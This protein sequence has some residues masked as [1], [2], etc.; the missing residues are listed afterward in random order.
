MIQTGVI[1]QVVCAVMAGGIL[2]YLGSNGRRNRS[3]HSYML[4]IGLLLLWHVAE[5]LLLLSQNS[6]QEM[7]ALKL[8]FLP[9]VYIGV[10]WLYFC[11]AI[12]QSPLARNKLL[13]TTMICI[14]AICYLFL[15][16]NDLHHLFYIEVIFKTK[17]YRGPVF[18]IH[19]VESYFCIFSGTIY[20]FLDLKKKFGKS[21][22]ENT[23]LVIAVLLPMVANFLML[24]EVIPN[25]GLDITPQVMLFTLICFGVAVYQK[26]FLNLIPVAARHFIEYMSDGII[27]IDRE[28]LIVGMNE[29]VNHLFPGLDLRIYD[30]TG[31]VSDYIRANDFSGE[32]MNLADSLG[33][34]NPLKTVK[35]NLNIEG[36]DICVEIRQLRGFDQS[37][38]GKMII[39]E[40]RREE[41]QLLSEIKNK[42]VLLT[43]ANE[44]LMHSNH[45]LTD[46]NYQLEQFS[47]TVEELAI[48][49]ERNRMGREVH[50]T[51]GHTLTLLITL[52]ENA[53][54]GLYENQHQVQDTLNTSIDLSR[55]AL[56][57]IRSCLKGLSLESFKKTELVEWLHQLA[58]TNAASGTEVRYSLPERLP[59]LDETIIMVIYRI[60]QESVTNAIRHGKAKMVNIIIKIQPHFLRI[61]ILDD[62]KGCKEIVKGYGLSGMEERVNRLGGNISFGSDGEKGFNVI[63]DLPVSEAVVSAVN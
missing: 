30:S 34:D 17:L 47:I 20:L 51:V 9:V 25:K 36:L 42:N 11:L 1:I 35:G 53:K 56:N 58:K 28:D 21:K 54:A 43:R 5:I 22:R 24:S 31:K 13:V 61:Y 44:K 18:W 60:C 49:R 10:C 41:Q 26:K 4:C 32:G 33:G 6:A 16:T 27:I 52:A 57:D 48:T 19:T 15:L 12:V 63:V 37:F 23:W 14:P 8:K 2:T 62:G 29:A 45:L 55:Q 59:A 50:D 38:A 7:A 46:L 40:D 39:I 3:T